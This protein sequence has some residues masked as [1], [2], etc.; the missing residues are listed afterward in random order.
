MLR[1]TL[2]ALTL[3]LFA[4]SAWAQESLIHVKS[5]VD[6]PTT[7]ER[8][9][10][11]AEAKEFTVVARVD[12][13]AAAARVGMELRPTTVVI[14][15][16]PKGGTPLMQCDQKAG[17]DLPLKVLVWEN[18][19]GETHLT[20]DQPR[21]LGQRHDMGNCARNLEG[22]GNVLQKLVGEAAGQ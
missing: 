22:V 9:A 19:A 14:F 7:V 13:A 1:N 11:A 15:G 20:Y 21:L 18:D 5:T 8:L 17:L 2:I 6:V 3:T 16:N 12:H 10:K 4:S